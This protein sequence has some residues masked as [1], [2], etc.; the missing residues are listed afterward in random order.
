MMKTMMQQKHAKSFAVND[1]GGCHDNTSNVWLLRS[2]K[3]KHDNDRRVFQRAMKHVPQN[4][5]EIVFEN[6]LPNINDLK[7]KASNSSL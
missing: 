1:V 5:L 2:R 3:T 6:M 4:E 7:K